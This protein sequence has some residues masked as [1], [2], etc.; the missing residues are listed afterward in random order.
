M[1]KVYIGICAS[2]MLA[3]ATMWLAPIQ[4]KVTAGDITGGKKAPHVNIAIFHK[5]HGHNDFVYPEDIAATD[6]LQVTAGKAQFI[7]ISHTSGLKD[8]DVITMNN[9]VLREG[10]K[11]FE[12][13]GVDCEIAFHVQASDVALS[14]MCQILMIDQDYREIDH[15][16][17]VKEHHIDTAKKEVWHLIYNDQEDGI[18]VYASAE[19]ELE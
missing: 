3:A 7:A 11:N 1:K 13:F 5:L 18:A 19:I 12:D 15:K 4:A 6:I 17:I 8:G 16:G 14:G 10:D 9:D 2:V